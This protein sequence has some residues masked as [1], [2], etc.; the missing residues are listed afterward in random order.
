VSEYE[1]LRIIVLT[2]LSEIH[3]RESADEAVNIAEGE[4]RM[5]KTMGVSPWFFIPA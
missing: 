1:C 5:S 3:G 4:L 2:C